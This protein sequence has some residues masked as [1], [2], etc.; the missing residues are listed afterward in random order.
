MIKTIQ[1]GISNLDI[2]ICLTFGAWN[3]V[4]LIIHL[5]STNHKEYP[6]HGEEDGTHPVR[7]KHRPLLG[8]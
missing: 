4:L 3:W 1:F 8:C 7:C 2:A 6:S 5:F